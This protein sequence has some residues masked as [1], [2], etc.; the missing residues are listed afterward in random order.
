MSWE[1]GVNNKRRLLCS[2]LLFICSLYSSSAQTTFSRIYFPCTNES[3][4]I[5]STDSGFI[6]FGQY[7]AYNSSFSLIRTDHS[8][9]ILSSSYSGNGYGFLERVTWDGHEYI[10][11]MNGNIPSNDSI[12]WIS[13]INKSGNLSWSRSYGFPNK[14]VF[15]Y[16]RIISTDDG[17]FLL[18]GIL[19]Q[20]PGTTGNFMLTKVD[21]SG[22]VQWAKSY[23]YS[24]NEIFSGITQ[25]SDN[26]YLLYGHILW[27][28]KTI[29]TKTDSSGN[30]QWT[31]FYYKALSSFPAQIK[32]DPFGNFVVFLIHQ[33][34]NFDNTFQVMALNNTGSI[35]WAKNYHPGI[36]F[37]NAIGEM[38]FSG[39][40]IVFTSSDD[41]T[42]VF[43]INNQGDLIWSKVVYD[44]IRGVSALSNGQLLLGGLKNF[45]SMYGIG[46]TLMNSDGTSCNS[47][48][49]GFT[50]DTVSFTD[51]SATIIENSCSVL[52]TLY[53]TSASIP[54][55]VDSLL[56]MVSEVSSKENNSIFTIFP[57]PTH[58]KFNILVNDYFKG[59]FFTVIILDFSGKV[60]YRATEKK[61]P[62]LIPEINVTPGIYIV[63]IQT[64]K[65]SSYK[66]LII[67]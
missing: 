20:I 50:V 49:T 5:F 4:C 62:S 15:G 19:Q 38:S 30:V 1:F 65:Y 31:S 18:G 45:S 11:A 7:P 67:Y 60:I 32:E 33:N 66:K 58:G 9:N 46:L 16:N 59:S 13:K 8:G 12:I 24:D 56:C 55:P 25:T 52:N 57:N 23:D 44:R 53:N 21:S 28:G 35:L 40:D 34:V 51:S 22:T 41:S 64:D 10:Y 48:S 63:S 39:N 26:G 27:G 14:T 17:G 36:I 43:K 42:F 6:I 29:V 54:G 61:E 2:L 37:H 3:N 47:F